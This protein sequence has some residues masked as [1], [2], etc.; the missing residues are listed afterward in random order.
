MDSFHYSV[1]AIALVALIIMF[2]IV[3]VMISMNNQNTTY[4]PIVN[5]CPNFW[6]KDGNGN[7]IIP[8]STSVNYPITTISADLPGKTTTYI[9]F[10]ND[11]WARYSGATSAVCAKKNWAVL[12]GVLWDGISNYNG[13]CK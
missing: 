13:V 5:D 10:R 2:I 12:N 9:D 1:L 7:C 3:G 11:G 6:S 8:I 4:P